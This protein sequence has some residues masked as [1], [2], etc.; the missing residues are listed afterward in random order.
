MKGVTMNNSQKH[1]GAF[2]DNDSRVLILGSF[3]SQD[4]LKAGFST[5]TAQ[6]VFGALCKRYL[7]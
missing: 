4:S 2:F 7:V 6:I 1:F 5:K 3:P